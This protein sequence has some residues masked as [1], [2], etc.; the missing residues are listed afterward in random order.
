MA[1]ELIETTLGSVCASQG[2]SVSTGP[3]GSQ[4]HASDYS[5]V[6]TPVVM[7]V[8]LVGGRVSENG[9][10]R[11]SNE[12]VTR[13]SRHRLS[14]GD[15]VFSRRGDVTRFALVS[16]RER[17]WL[18]GT[19]CLK[20]SLGDPLLATPEFIAAYLSSPDAKEW[21]VRHAVG[22]TMPNL[23]TEILSDVPITLPPLADQVE[24]GAFLAAIDLRIDLL[25]QTNTTL[26]AIAQSLFKSWFV[27][28]DPVRAKAE[29][30]EPNGMDAETAALFPGDFEE[31]ELGLIPKGWTIRPF[32]S[33]FEFTMGQ[34]PPGDSYNDSGNGTPFFQ[35]CTDFGD[36]S[37]RR[38]VFTTQPT[39]FARAGDVLM[40]VRAPV[41]DINVA[42][43]D[44][45]IGRGLCSI[46]HR[47]GS[48]GLTV[49]SIGA[50]RA[51]I[52]TAAGEGALFKSLSKKQLSELPVIS[53]GDHL[54][55][56]GSSVLDPLVRSRL[57]NAKR[58][59]VLT[60]LRDT[61]LP[62]LISGRLRLPDVNSVIEEA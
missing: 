28:F 10:A 26:E 32:T 33:E 22:A 2:G 17:G 58:I 15:I 60:S 13:L 44:C 47:S 53:F 62:R 14:P 43:S 52:E 31:S 3:F 23:N 11:V 42:S 54:A 8:N 55:H 56:A 34:S 40:S 6:G 38:R 5:D 30:S 29:G 4:L 39:R 16:E 35:G 1:F 49:A 61:L 20:I 18:C 25:R 27:D 9:I 37:P 21:L 57:A 24:I 51:R 19:G 45:S 48:T 41:G 46:R 50:M 12:H 7:P 36:V 59:E